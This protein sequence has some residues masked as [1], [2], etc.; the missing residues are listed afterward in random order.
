MVKWRKK[1]DGKYVEMQ[2]SIPPAIG[3]S[4]KFMGGVDLSDQIIQYYGVLRKTRKWWKTLF[5]HFIDV[6]VVNAFIF[7][8]S[9]PGKEKT[10]HKDFREQL[11]LEI[12]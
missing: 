12:V 8:R 4:N 6:C 10:S 3:N 5:F 7:Y 9:L 1:I 2:V 11:L